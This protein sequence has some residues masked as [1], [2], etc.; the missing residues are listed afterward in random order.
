MT[1][2][3][4]LIR[5]QLQRASLR[6]G[7]LTIG[8][9]LCWVGCISS[10]INGVSSSSAVEA[11]AIVGKSNL[12][13]SQVHLTDPKEIEEILQLIRDIRGTKFMRANFDMKSAQVMTIEIRQKDQSTR[14]VMVSGFMVV[15]DRSL[16]EDKSVFYDSSRQVQ[17]KLWEILLEHLGQ[18]SDQAQR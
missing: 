16:G 18:T 7:V 9:L 15:P 8:L 10:P 17:A 11:I 13:D 5:D 6:G 4:N 3:L 12:G 1:T 14:L 2:R